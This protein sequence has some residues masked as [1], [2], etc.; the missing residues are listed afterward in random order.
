MF[1]QHVYSVNA[2][3]L[4]LQGCYSGSGKRPP[5][6][7]TAPQ[8]KNE[9]A[10]KIEQHSGQCRVRIVPKKRTDSRAAPL[11]NRMSYITLEISITM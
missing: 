5:L 3:L 6:A 8:R 11:E 9:I 7:Y 1:F 10:G 2:V 4:D